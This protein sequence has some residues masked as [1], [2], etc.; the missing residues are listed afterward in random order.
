MGQTCLKKSLPLIKDTA[1]IHLIYDG[2]SIIRTFSR[3]PDHLFLPYPTPLALV[4][5]MLPFPTYSL[6]VSRGAIRRYHRRLL[7]R[8]PSEP[9]PFT[10]TILATKQEISWRSGHIVSPSSAFS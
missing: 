7:V 10:P 6:T 4:P 8:S 1:C 3:L 9:L 2:T 5:A